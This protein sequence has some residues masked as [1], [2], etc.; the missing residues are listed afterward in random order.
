MLLENAGV[1]AE[2][3][4]PELGLLCRD[5]GAFRDSEI[6]KAICLF[7]TV[8]GR[9]MGSCPPSAGGR[10]IPASWIFAGPSGGAS[11]PAEACTVSIPASPEPEAK[12][13][14]LVR[15]VGLHGPVFGVCPAVYPV[16]EPGGGE[17]QNLPVFG[18]RCGGDAF[19]LQNMDR[20]RDTVRASGIYGRGTD[21]GLCSGRSSAT[22]APQF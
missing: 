17:F 20:F 6:P 10:P 1:G 19:Q 8:P 4:D 18:N 7:K 13:C 12:A 2:E 22:V 21:L 5:I 11:A 15:R 9:S 14:D 16:L 3:L